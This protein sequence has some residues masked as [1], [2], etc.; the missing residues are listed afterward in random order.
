MH[1]QDFETGWPADDRRLVVTGR[2][3]WDDDP[4][5]R[6]EGRRGNGRG[7]PGWARE[8][9]WWLAAV[10]LATSAALAGA[11]ARQR[12]AP[13]V[14]RWADDAPGTAARHRSLSRAP[15][16][17]AAVTI[18]STR[19][20][21]F[22]FVREHGNLPRFMTGARVSSAPGAN[23]MD[24]RMRGP[25]GRRVDVP[26][27]LVDE[28]EGQWLV[29]VS[30]DD[31]PFRLEYRLEFSDAPGE[32]GTRVHAILDWSPPAGL[33]GHWLAKALR[34]DPGTRARRDLRRLKM[35]CEAGEIATSANRRPSREGE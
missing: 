22:S 13:R 17:G 34:A 32:R 29:W 35:L 31:A 19:A 15:L 2:A 10:G 7:A 5:G 6:Y 23:R 8:N 25:R 18:A 16:L 11:A 1:E 24:W 26:V 21:V 14:L 33:A 12:Q 20:E 9:V 30:E 3:R 27:S 4:R 28:R